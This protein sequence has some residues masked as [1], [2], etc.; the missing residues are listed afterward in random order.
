MKT[1]HTVKRKDEAKWGTY[2]T[3]D[4]ILEIYDA[5]AA[6]TQTGQPYQT[7]LNP[8]PANPC[9]AYPARHSLLERRNGVSPAYPILEVTRG[10]LY[11]PC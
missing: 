4:T 5:L 2:R 10:C 1:C 11:S 6:A 7:R 8:G 9:V 3:K